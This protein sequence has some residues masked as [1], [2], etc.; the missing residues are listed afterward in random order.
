MNAREQRFRFDH[1][2]SNTEN[3]LGMMEKRKT[4]ML[5]FEISWDQRRPRPRSTLFELFFS[6]ISVKSSIFSSRLD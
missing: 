6:Y 5:K 3:Q 4:Q 2:T 1:V